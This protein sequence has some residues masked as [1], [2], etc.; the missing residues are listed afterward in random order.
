MKPWVRDDPGTLHLECWKIKARLVCA[1]AVGTVS[2]CLGRRKITARSAFHHA[3]LQVRFE[4]KTAS[5]HGEACR[6]ALL[7]L[8][9]FSTGPALFPYLSRDKRP[10]QI[11]SD[12]TF[13]LLRE[14]S[15]PPSSKCTVRHPEEAFHPVKLPLSMEPVTIIADWLIYINYH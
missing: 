13:Q 5:L 6:L 8:P 2:M 14:G 7:S 9:Q 4:N 12:F 15:V 11:L 3:H 1:A 10:F